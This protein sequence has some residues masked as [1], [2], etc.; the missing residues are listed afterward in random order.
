MTGTIPSEIGN[1]ASSLTFLSAS[2]T[3]LQGPLPTE[4]GRLDLLVFYLMNYC[5]MGGTTI[6]TEIGRCRSLSMSQFRRFISAFV[7]LVAQIR[8]SLNIDTLSL[9]GNMFSGSL[10]SELGLL[11]NLLQL[12]ARNNLLTG[13]VPS[14]LLMLTELR[15]LQ[16][17][18]N[19]RMT[20][21]IPEEFC[22]MDNLREIT[23]DCGVVCQCCES[24]LDTECDA[25]NSG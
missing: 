15:S 4:I 9:E 23:S 20:G 12:R 21:S 10:P 13:I 1:L 2:F 11:T 7:T 18:L 8:F 17:A 22:G 3:S 24:S 6:P 5:S 16:L 25:Q 14:Q 19:P